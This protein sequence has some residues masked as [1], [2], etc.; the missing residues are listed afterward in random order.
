[1]MLLAGPHSLSRAY[2]KY[3]TDCVTGYKLPAA[4]TGTCALRPSMVSSF[5]VK[6]AHAT[7]HGVSL[8]IQQTGHTHV[9][10][11]H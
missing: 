11:N 1:M 8:P 4:L 7:G 6:C 10:H 5:Q 9:S 3:E 2:R